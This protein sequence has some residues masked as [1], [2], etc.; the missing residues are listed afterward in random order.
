[1]I[2]Q[3]SYTVGNIN[4]MCYVLNSILYDV[5]SHLQLALLPYY[6]GEL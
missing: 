1:M 3:L 2:L 5:L 4:I 6:T